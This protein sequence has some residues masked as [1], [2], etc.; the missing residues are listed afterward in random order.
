MKKST[1]KL[2]IVKNQKVLT[3][4]NISSFSFSFTFNFHIAFIKQFEAYYKNINTLPLIFF[5]PL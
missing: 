3:T 1:N 4:K 5:S 2:V